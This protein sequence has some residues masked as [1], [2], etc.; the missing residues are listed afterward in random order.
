M[1]ITAKD[2]LGYSVWVPMPAFIPWNEQMSAHDLK[3]RYA[4]YRYS[5]VIHNL[6]FNQEN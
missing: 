4:V 3:I 2:L 1:L 6:S 5:P